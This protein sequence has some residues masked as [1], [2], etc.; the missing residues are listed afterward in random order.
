MLSG[1]L[2]GLTQTLS[3][4]VEYNLE[5]HNLT[6]PINQLIGEPITIRFTGERRCIAC[7]R[8]VNK[9]FQN[10][11][12][13]PCVRTLAECDLC[14]VKPHECHF[15]LGTCRD[16]AFAEDH[17]MIPHYV[18]LAWSSGFKVG[19]TRKGRQ[20]KR[21]MDQGATL[22]MVIAELPTRKMAGEVEM[23]IAKHMRDKTDWRKMLREDSEPDRSLAD[24]RADVLSNLP[25]TYHE[26][27]LPDPGVAQEIRYPRKEGFS[28]NL[29][30]LNLDKEPIFTGTLRGIKGQYLLFDEGVMNIKKFS[31]YGVEISSSAFGG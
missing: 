22:A 19:L 13:F 14:I 31:G 8:E 7:G 5:L 29:K 9:L 3:D 21:W 15:H 11:Y 17:C 27:I 30:S 23:E 25:E 16:E 4:P 28:V 18:Y 10:G 6:M 2:R 24:V 20:L 12:C 1:D 26:Y